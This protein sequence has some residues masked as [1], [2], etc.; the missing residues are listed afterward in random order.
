[1]LSDREPSSSPPSLS[2]FALCRFWEADSTP[3]NAQVLP[4]E[5]PSHISLSLTSLLV[6]TLLIVFL[7]SIDCSFCVPLSFLLVLLFGCPSVQDPRRPALFYTH[8][9]NN[10]HRSLREQETGSDGTGRNP[11]VSDDNRKPGHTCKYVP[12]CLLRLYL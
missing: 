6:V 11:I 1:M 7:A 5:S 12:L 10:R 8:A 2:V 9:R 3:W 4:A